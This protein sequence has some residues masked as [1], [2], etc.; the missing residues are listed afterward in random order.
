VALLRFAAPQAVDLLRTGDGRPLRDALMG[1]IGVEIFGAPDDPEVDPGFL[2]AL[3]EHVL[4][5]EKVEGPA[6]LSISFVDVETMAE[7]NGSY[8]S[9]EAPTDVLAFGIDIPSV[10]SVHPG[11]PGAA[12]LSN[13]PTGL[14]LEGGSGPPAMLGDVVIC[15]EVARRNAVDHGVSLAQELALLVVHGVLH[16]LGMDHENPSE[17]ASMEAREAHYLGSFTGSAIR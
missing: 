11:H 5:N 2:A 6:E 12:K 3:A 17:A 14:E 7:L 15:T 16:I 13:G 9:N 10:G 4:L 1:A 8:R